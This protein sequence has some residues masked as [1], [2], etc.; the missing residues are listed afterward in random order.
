M[1]K[2]TTLLVFLVPLFLMICPSAFAQSTGLTVTTDKQ[3]YADGDTMVIS[4]I[5]Q[6]YVANIPLSIKVKDPL[7]NIVMLAQVDVNSDKTYSTSITA[8]GN[9]WK[10]I[11]TYEIDAQYT[12]DMSAKATFQFSGSP[13]VPVNG[14]NLSVTYNIINGK[15]LGINADV[16]SKTLII[17]M[18]TTGDGML[19]LTLPRALID[20]KTNG[21]DGKFDVLADRVQSTYNETVT[22]SNRTLAIQFVNGTKEIQITGTQLV[23]EFGPVASLIFVIAIV[24]IIAISAKTKF[25]SK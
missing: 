10:A 3:S 24:S 6:N 19:T 1:R 7:G 9:L 11:G 25:L 4:G 8:G 23:P 13:S 18:Q 20:A 14:T 12:K 21:Q 5:A 2:T 17:S 22:D 16:P 15:V